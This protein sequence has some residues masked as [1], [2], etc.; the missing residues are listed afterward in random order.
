[1]VQN[2]LE[3]LPHW[4][5]CLGGTSARCV[6]F[7]GIIVQKGNPLLAIVHGQKALVPHGFN[8]IRRFRFLVWICTA[9]EGE[10]SIEVQEALLRGI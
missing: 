1:M 10:R 8:D 5:L 6:G 2:A 3:P 4:L 7:E 9:N